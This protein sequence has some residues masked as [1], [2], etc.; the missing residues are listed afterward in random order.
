[1]SS[2]KHY[3]QVEKAV[4]AQQALIGDINALG[5]DIERCEKEI[6]ELTTQ[7]AE[8]NTKHQGAASTR[9]QIDYLE[10]LLK[11]LH[12]KL[13]WEKHLASLKKRT[14]ELLEEMTKVLND[15]VAPPDQKMREELLRSLQAVQAAMERLTSVQPV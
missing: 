12:K 1:M 4:A 7:L 5:K 6:V 8:V 13:V 3:K 14:P 15:P 2:L 11:C 10:D 9:A